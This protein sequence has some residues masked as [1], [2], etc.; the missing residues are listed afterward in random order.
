[1]YNSDAGSWIIDGEA[2]DNLDAMYAS[3][4]IHMGLEI[5]SH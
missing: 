5:D 3:I 4:C 1:M 2:E